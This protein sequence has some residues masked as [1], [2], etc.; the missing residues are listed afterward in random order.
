MQ[1]LLGQHRAGYVLSQD[2][3]S[4][5]S[6]FGLELLSNSYPHYLLDIPARE[7][8]SPGDF[9]THQVGQ[10]SLVIARDSDS[11]IC[12]FHNVSRHKLPLV[13]VF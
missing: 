9:C 8:P 10:Y 11:Q 5:G 6:A 4:N 7:I 13:R 1:T 12:A 2:L 3:Y